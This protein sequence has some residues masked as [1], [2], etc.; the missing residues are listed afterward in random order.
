MVQRVGEPRKKMQI[1]HKI[2]SFFGSA[3]EKN[4]TTSAVTWVIHLQSPVGN[5]AG[6]KK[7]NIETNSNGIDPVT[8]NGT[9]AQIYEIGIPSKEITSTMKEKP[10]LLVKVKAKLYYG[11]KTMAK[12][13]R[14]PRTT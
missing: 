10:N 5:Q 7:L 1:K 6:I 8:K 12:K 4:Y 13:Q 14:I 2:I 3:Q 9:T 11:I